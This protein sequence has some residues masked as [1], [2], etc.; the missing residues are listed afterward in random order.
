M[1]PKRRTRL[2]I[3]QGEARILP[4]SRIESAPPTPHPPRIFCP[5]RAATLARENVHKGTARGSPM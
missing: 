3:L 2:S 5:R 1:G 4:Q